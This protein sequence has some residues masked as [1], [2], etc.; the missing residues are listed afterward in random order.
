MDYWSSIIL[1]V[2]KVMKTLVNILCNLYGRSAAL[3][4]TDEKQ[5]AYS[6]KPKIRLDC[7]TEKGEINSYP[8][9]IMNIKPE[10][11][12]LLWAFLEGL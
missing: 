6:T 10:D 3:E 1:N 4:S 12:L 11:R 5:A 8:A 2:K 9:P 7:R